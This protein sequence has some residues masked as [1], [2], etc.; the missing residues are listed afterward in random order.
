MR[1]MS[2]V[3]N[4]VKKSD[5]REKKIIN[6]LPCYSTRDFSYTDKKE[7]FD[8]IIKSSYIYQAILVLWHFYSS[9][10]SLNLWK[11][12]LLNSFC[13]NALTSTNSWINFNNVM[14][15]MVVCPSKFYA[16]E[17]DVGR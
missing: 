1:N 16:L 14:I 2:F 13:K 7:N 3:Q 15:R 17:F 9:L 8:P 12:T 5:G 10:C 6:M 11:N 4:L